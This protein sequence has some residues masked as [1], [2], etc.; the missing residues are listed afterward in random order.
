MTD[1]LGVAII[2]YAFMGKAHSAAW[3]NVAASFDV[4]AYQQRVL[5]GRTATAARQAAERY[6]WQ[7]S[8]TDWREL[9][10]R[11]DIH[12]VDICTPGWNHAEIAI[13][14][15]A[16]G[17]HV[18]VE[19]PLANS[20][21]EATEMV[22]AAEEAAQRGVRSMLG[23]NYRRIPA[24]VLARGLVAQGRLGTIRQVRAAY[25]QDWLSDPAAAMSWRLRKETAGSG[26]LGDIASHAVDLLQFV[27]SEQAV[28][29]TGRLHTFV[30]ERPGPNGREPVTVDDAVWANLELA[31]GAIASV[32]ASRVATGQK[33]SLQLEVYGSA[34]ALRFDLERL[35]ELEFLDASQA[36]P[37]Q[38][39]RKILCT[40]SSHP[41]LQAWWPPG[42]IIGWEHTFS[43][44]IRDFLLNIAEGTDP[45][46]SFAD[47][48][49]VQRV[50]EAISDS[51]SSGGQRRQL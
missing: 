25:L 50:L 6:G 12:I 19:K 14:A 49:Q 41:Y 13:A 45:S 51:S 26:A 11:D 31:S 10:E 36:L 3:R 1:P 21:A 16:A 33:N 2:G 28:S 43:H 42:H 32:E 29:A 35:N 48:L 4:P 39:F 47:G 8:S 9:L 34:G 27:L 23:F 5:V 46:P 7:Q 30:T 24:L 37:E 22:R 18:L 40:E 17:K 38:G 20:V 44:Q 15:L